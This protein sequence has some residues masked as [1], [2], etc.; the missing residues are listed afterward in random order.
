M[1]KAKKKVALEKKA[2]KGKAKAKKTKIVVDLA[3]D[4]MGIADG[5]MKDAFRNAFLR[6]EI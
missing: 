2:S 4:S 6:R 5:Q 1:A 3:T